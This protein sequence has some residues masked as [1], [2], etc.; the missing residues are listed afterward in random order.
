MRGFGATGKTLPVT[1]L[2]R[3][4]PSASGL[5]LILTAGFPAFAQPAANDARPSLLIVTVDTTRWDRLQPY[6]ATNVATPALAALAAEGAVF[7]QAY[8]VAPITLPAHA[9]ILSGL[10]P[11]QTGVRNNGTHYVSAETITLAERLRPLGFRTAAFV[12]AAVLERRYGLDQGF[13]V[14]DDDLSTGRE[15]HARIVPDRPAEATIASAGAWLD[16]LDA[17]ESLFLWVHLYDPHAV[18][19]PPPPFRDEYRG[20][21]YDGEIAYMDQQIGRLLAHPAL[22]SREGLMVMVLADHGESLGEHGEQTHGIL[23][24]DS[25]LHIP[26]LMKLPGVPG[27]VRVQQMVSQVDVVPTILDALDLDPEASLPGRSVL[28]YV[29]GVRAATTGY[30]E[31]YLPFYTYGWAKLRVYRR[32]RWKLIDGRRP[33][34][35]DL[36]RDPRELSNLSASEPGVVHDMKRDLDAF[37][38]SVTVPER[39]QSLPLDSATAERLRS[40]GYLATGSGTDDATVDDAR[41]DPR[42]VIDLHVGLE[43][44]RT[45]MR[46]RLYADAERRLRAVLDKDPNNL[47][48]LVD[49]VTALEGQERVDEAL[50]A[51]ARADSVDPKYARLK[52][53]RASLEIRLKRPREA[54]TFL[55]QALELDPRY[56]DA[57]IRKAGLLDEL[58]ESARAEQVLD[59][60]LK[61]DSQDPWANVVYA[62]IVELR[63]NDLVAAEKRLRAAVARDPFFAQGWSILGLVLARDGRTTDAIETYREALRR[64]PDF[65]EA[66]TNLGILLARQGAGAEAESHLR[67]GIRLSREY[68]TDAH[69]ALGAWLAEHGRFDEAQKEYASVLEHEPDNIG[70]RNNRAIAMFQAGKLDDAERE[71]TALV[72]EWPDNVDAHANLAVIALERRNWKR[73]ESEAR[74]ALAKNPKLAAAWSNL[75][76]ALDEQGDLEGAERAL[77]TAVDVDPTYWQ[78]RNNL[79]TTLRKMGRASE[80]GAMFAEVLEQVPDE[81]EV[82]LELGDLYYG[83]LADAERARAHYNAV[84]KY[85]PNHSRAAEIRQ[86]VSGGAAASS[87]AATPSGGPVGK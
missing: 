68:R 85:A 76:I 46:D 8:A 73:A 10:Y 52:L 3:L 9:S 44:A 65:E 57:A 84:L 27:G 40:L 20:R 86:R 58:G 4:L 33:E 15:R 83:P 70:A 36:S 37:L 18:Y 38:D 24:Y 59:D 6:G 60:V 47:A 50:E 54:L 28:P 32:D 5:L 35:F 13:E 61:L 26:F 21:L 64:V 51:L 42:D 45:L 25:T 23:A 53:L 17:K 74:L 41:P 1:N 69:L 75:G 87:A 56:Q 29:R 79:A 7:E 82:H 14:Y 55:D 81:P 22:A 66:H 12:S 62:Q 78:A 71:L 16:T 39:E 34:L 80:A 31:S 11:P 2:R 48:A 63:R 67:E 43:R 49:L 30:A 77:R 19:S 72:A